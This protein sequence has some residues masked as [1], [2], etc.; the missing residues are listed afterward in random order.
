MKQKQRPSQMWV[1]LIQSVEGLSRTKPDVPMQKGI[2]QAAW[3]RT[4]PEASALPPW[5]V[6]DPHSAPGTRTEAGKQRLGRLWGR[7]RDTGVHPL[8]REELRCPT[9]Y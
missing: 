3:L 1:G 6:Q 9:G 8:V 5:Q 7:E 4:P 2:R